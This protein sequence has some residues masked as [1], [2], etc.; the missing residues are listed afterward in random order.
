MGIAWLGEAQDVVVDDL[1]RAQNADDRSERQE[2]G[3]WL[4][5]LLSD[6]P[7]AAKDVFTEGKRLGFSERTIWRAKKTLGILSTKPPEG[8]TFQWLLP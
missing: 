5:D 1:L 8:R 2:A 6:G 3:T 7:H 4:R